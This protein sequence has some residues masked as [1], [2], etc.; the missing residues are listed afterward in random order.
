M[1]RIY[2][3]DDLQP[4]LGQLLQGRESGEYNMARSAGDYCKA[5]RKEKNI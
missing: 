2:E 3:Y 5:S 4:V 1:R